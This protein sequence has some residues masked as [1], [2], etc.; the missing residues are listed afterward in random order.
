M[1]GNE[2]ISSSVK[3]LPDLEAH[4]PQVKQRVKAGFRDV[5]DRARTL[6]YEQRCH[7]SITMNQYQLGKYLTGK[8]D[9]GE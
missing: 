4:Q 2:P 6:V 9:H 3:S 1:I 5:S 7:R 8:K